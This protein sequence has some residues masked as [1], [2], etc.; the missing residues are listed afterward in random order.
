MKILLDDNTYITAGIEKADRQEYFDALC[1][2]ARA[3]SYESILNQIGCLCK[4]HNLGY[5]CELYRILL[6]RY[7]F[8]HN[9]YSDLCLLGDAVED[10]R[11]YFG[12]GAKGSYAQKSLHKISADEELLGFYPADSGDYDIDAED[13]FSDAIFDDSDDSQ[14]H[15]SV[16]FDIHS[17]EYYDNLR[18]RMEK[19]YWHGNLSEG[20]RLQREY[21]S[22]DT[23][24]LPT[25]EMQLFIC[26]TE[27]NWQQGLPLALKLCNNDNATFRG[28][29]SAIRILAHCDEQYLPQLKTLLRRIADFG[30]DV[31]DPDMTDY[32][33]ICC[34]NFGYGKE[35][36]ALCNILFG[37]Y[38]DA[39]CDA[40]RLCG[41]VFYNAKQYALARQAAVLLLRATPW[42]CYAHLLVKFVKSRLS[43]KLDL[44]MGINTL[45]RFFDVSV[46][47]AAW[48]EYKLLEIIDAQQGVLHPDQYVYLECIANVCRSCIVNGDEEHYMSE[49]AALEAF[50]GNI[51]SVDVHFE[52]FAR[53]QL[54]AI[55][56]E[57]TLN[58]QLLSILIHHGCKG[59]VLVALSFGYYALDLPASDCDG[60][61]AE[62]L[63]VCATVRKIDTAR[64]RK[65][66]DALFE[67][68]DVPAHIDATAIR[69]VAYCLLAMAYKGFCQ[70]NESAFFVKDE[71]EMYL[72]YLDAISAK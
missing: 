7:N 46:Q 68:I 19:A 63:T 37:H 28:I 55:V 38:R 39:G 48:S 44:P 32:L 10:V 14:S 57:P 18:T 24:S 52:Q 72:R 60:L 16:F 12:N 34:K 23:D 33:Q 71:N 21:M 61:F 4:L 36:V 22:L 3:D 43:V 56:P 30:D 66:F 20:K 40:L 51:K 47:F 17:P 54:G 1:L 49:A 62:A 50:V 53:R 25:L 9:C 59:K 42:D 64:L 35:S 29:G 11:L 31:P 58:R 2:F 70:S 5:A 13:L 45:A 65:C 67:V 6:T 26:V 41:L 8:T 15:E 27:Q 69:S